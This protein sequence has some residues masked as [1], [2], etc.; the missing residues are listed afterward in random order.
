MWAQEW[1]Q[2]SRG[3]L[4][5]GGAGTRRSGPLESRSSKARLVPAYEMAPELRQSPDDPC[6]EPHDENSTGQEDDRCPSKPDNGSSDDKRQ[7]IDVACE[8]GVDVL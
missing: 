7:L 5:G 4:I 3:C 1:A 8:V 2:G 6:P